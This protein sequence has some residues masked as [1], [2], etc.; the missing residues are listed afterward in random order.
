VLRTAI[1]I[2]SALDA[3]HAHGVVHRDVKPS[4]VILT[5]A[6][7]KL[8]DFGVA[9]VPRRVEV[10]GQS[11]LTADPAPTAK[12]A[13]IGT[14]Q[15]MAPEQLEGKDVDA[16]ADI[17]AFGAVL[18]EMATGRRAFDG[19]TQGNVTA[20]IME[21]QPPAFSEAGI[22]TPPAFDLLVR[23]CLAKDPDQRWQSARD[24]LFHLK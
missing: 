4:N 3:A 19:E 24:V 9:K 15:Y 18:Y 22:A 7:A 23:R 5:K 2:A 20:A 1:E 10:G 11:T 12:G 13:I 16:R 8:L 14:F 17:F 6:G 21:R